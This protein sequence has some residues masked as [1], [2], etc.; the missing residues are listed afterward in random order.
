MWCPSCKVEYRAGFDR[1]TDCDCL[2]V[3]ILEDEVRSQPEYDH[4]VFLISVRDNIEADVIEALLKANGIP[5]LRKFKDVGGY[6]TIY[7]GNTNTGVDIYVPSTLY[8]KA[9]DLVNSENEQA[10]EV[11]KT[12]EEEDADFLNDA[13]TVRKRKSLGAWLIL[14]VFFPGLLFIAIKLIAFCLKLIS[15]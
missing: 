6:L 9:K 14:I 1:C 3:E 5:T 8:Q 12:L 7:M 11:D 13:E 15:F 10:F 2:L 4:E